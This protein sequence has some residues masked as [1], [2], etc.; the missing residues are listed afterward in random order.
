MT[1]RELASKGKFE[2]LQNRHSYLENLS[3]FPCYTVNS[4]TYFLYKT[5][6]DPKSTNGV[7]HQSWIWIFPDTKPLV[8][9]NHNTKESR[10]YLSVLV[11]RELLRA[12][13]HLSVTG[14]EI[15]MKF[16]FKIPLKMSNYYEKRKELFQ[17]KRQTSAYYICR[18]MIRHYPK[19]CVEPVYITLISTGTCEICNSVN[20][21]IV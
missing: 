2:R 9:N 18:K 5:V 11:E 6:N 4:M 3:V 7:K 10:T 13:S 8:E 20:P 17:T 16:L 15:Y 21:G 14:I 12:S 19:S 1:L